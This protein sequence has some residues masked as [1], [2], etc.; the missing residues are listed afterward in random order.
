MADES[1]S[2]AHKGEEPVT[3]TADQPLKV[4]D[5]ISFFVPFSSAEIHRSTFALLFALRPFS[6]CFFHPKN[7]SAAIRVG[8][9]SLNNDR[10]KY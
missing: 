10:R 8:S 1:R 9:R 7:G 6:R 2:V 5:Q 4:Y 3:R